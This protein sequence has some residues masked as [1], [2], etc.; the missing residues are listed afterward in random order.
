MDQSSID[1]IN[2]TNYFKGNY[3]KGAA[4]LRGILDEPALYARFKADL[5]AMSSVIAPYDKSTVGMMQ[6]V[7]DTGLG[8]DLAAAYAVAAG[9]G[10]VG[11]M[12]Q[13]AP[14]SVL[15]NVSLMSDAL[16]EEIY[17]DAA[18][19]QAAM[20]SGIGC[21][22]R[23]AGC[24]AG[25]EAGFAALSG[26]RDYLLTLMEDADRLDEWWGSDHIWAGLAA[27]SPVV[28]ADPAAFSGFVGRQKSI[29]IDGYSG[30]DDNAFKLTVVAVGHNEKAAGG[31]AGFTFQ[32]DKIIADHAMSSSST[33]SGG[34][35]SSEMRAWLSGTLLPCFPEE[36]REAIE[37]ASISY[38]TASGSAL[39][40]CED[41]L[42]LPSEREVFGSSSYDSAGEQ[43]AWYA[44]AN[45]KV[46]DISFD[47]A[48]MESPW[49]LRSVH[50]SSHFRAVNSDGDANYYYATYVTG[51]APC[52]CI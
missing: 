36:V 1:L 23:I 9:Y 4:R 29:L 33:T 48:W 43:L 52:F 24:I 42:W 31:P 32:S 12:I 34:W 6:Q 38:N 11:N 46:K 44:E 39:S 3:R 2:W 8:D 28:A 51:V 16:A 10:G 21:V 50:G 25:T 5:A 45:T 35:G 22:P 26:D 49:W 47:G 19:V 30:E 14:T 20:A 41:S 7:Y 18:T 15:L 40:T 37:P 17:S 13:T 27:A